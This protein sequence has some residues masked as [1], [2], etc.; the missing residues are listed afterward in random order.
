MF[1]NI[2]IIFR[3]DLGGVGPC[4]GDSGGPLVC[5]NHTTLSFELHGVTS[6]GVGCA[7]PQSPAVYA[8]VTQFLEWINSTM[9]ISS[10]K[11]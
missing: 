1:F 11:S 5:Q 8:R 4:Q 2:K 6:F 7:L 10:S 3:F 9:Q